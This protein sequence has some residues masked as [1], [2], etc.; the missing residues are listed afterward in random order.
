[1][2]DKRTKSARE[3]AARMT[4]AER[5][6]QENS[7]IKKAFT[8]MS[9]QA[10]KAMFVYPL[11]DPFVAWGQRAYEKEELERQHEE[12]IDELLQG[13]LKKPESTTSSKPTKR[14]K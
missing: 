5:L 13:V 8:N 1:M 6:R 11:L 3:E 7:E 10:K 9:Q 4:Q 2:R 12:L 14:K